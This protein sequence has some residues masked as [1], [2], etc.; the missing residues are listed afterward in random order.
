MVGN[1]VRN[2]GI[3]LADDFILIRH[4]NHR[5]QYI[6]LLQGFYLYTGYTEIVYSILFK[7]QG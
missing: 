2:N 7:D 3:E 4:L 6:L 5:I 1:Y